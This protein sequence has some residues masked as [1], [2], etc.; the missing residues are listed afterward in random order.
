MS[1]NWENRLSKEELANL[2]TMEDKLTQFCKLHEG[3]FPLLLTSGGTS[4]PLE[5]RT[6]RFI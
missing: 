1:E 6:V 3:K 2:K 4:V 5:K